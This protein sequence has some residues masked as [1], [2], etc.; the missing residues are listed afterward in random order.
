MAESVDYNSPDL[1]DK[2]WFELV[3]AIARQIMWDASAILQTYYRGDALE[4][5]QQQDGPVTAADLAVNQHILK[6]LQAVFDP[7]AFGYLSEETY[8]AQA[9]TSTLP[10]VWVIDPLDGTKD[11]INKTGEYAIHLALV[12]QHRPVIS[13]V[14]IPEREL[15]YFAWLGGGTYREESDRTIT[16]VQIGDRR[17][18]TNL[19]EMTLVASRTHRNLRFELLIDKI[20]FQECRS[21]G[22]VGCKIASIIEQQTDVYISLSGE[23]APKDWD[24]AAP[25]L[26]LLEAG[27]VLSRA[28]G[29]PLQYNTG[30]VSQWGCIIASN[31]ANHGEICQTATAIL[32]DIDN[33]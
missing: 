10:W 3:I 12:Y 28:D 29:S 20:A 22:S 27:G 31:G 14:A 21:I 1:A 4:I 23:S 16:R 5:K 24:L 2:A 9:V 15:V 13:L 19:R 18:I 11:F 32:A 17:R 26:I 8:K 33:S 6:S 25:E 7:N 30:N